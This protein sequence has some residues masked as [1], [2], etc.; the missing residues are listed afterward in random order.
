MNMR[1]PCKNTP[2]MLESNMKNARAEQIIF[3]LKQ[4]IEV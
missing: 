3:L 1:I 2:N 4:E